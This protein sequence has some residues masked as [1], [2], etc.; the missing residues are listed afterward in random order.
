MVDNPAVADPAAD[1]V[2]TKD[3]A[4]STLTPE[5]NWKDDLS[6]D[7][8]EHPAFTNFKTVED[9]AKSHL[10]AQDKIGKK[11][12]PL[13]NKE[14]LM[15]SPEWGEVFNQL[16]RPV[17]AAGYEDP[18]LE[19]PAGQDPPDEKLMGEFKTLAH[20]I[21]LLPHQ[22]QALLKYDL[23]KNV[24]LG[25]QA[26]VAQTEELQNTET[27]LRKTMGKAYD[28]QLAKAKGLITKFGGDEVSAK[29]ANSGL[30]RDSVF[31][32][33]LMNIA[34]NFGEGGEL[35]GEPVNASILSPEQAGKRIKQIQGDKEHPFHKR[36]HPEHKEAMAEMTGLFQMQNPEQVA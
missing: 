32:Q 16:G 2:V 20:S 19:I 31:I 11:G 25:T 21:G 10:S 4:I 1:P 5:K 6:P 15:D 24:A 8:K 7:L 36:D 27:A 3:P 26:Q 35:L 9:L 17:E 18:K 12:I 33:F 29:I 22:Y 34:K 23:E 13:P 30:G 28:G 14:S